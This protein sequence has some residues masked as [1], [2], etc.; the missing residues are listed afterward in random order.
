MNRYILVLD[1]I[2]DISVWNMMKGVL[3][4]NNAGSKIITTTRNSDVSQQVGGTYKLKP[5]CLH[6]SKIL[7]YRRI[8]ANEDRDKCPN[9]ELADISEEMCWCTLS[10]HY[11]S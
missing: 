3:P 6:D 1:D 9:E 10:Y 4:D 7:L 5:L 11:D 2:W 8:F